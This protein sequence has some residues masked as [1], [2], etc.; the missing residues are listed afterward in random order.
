MRSA[1]TRSTLL[2]GAIASLFTASCLA[3]TG[4]LV[5][6]VL[7]K[8]SKEQ[9]AARMH[10]KDGKGKPVKPAKSVYWHDHFVFDGMISLKLRPG[11]YEYELECGPEYKLAVGNFE[12]DKTT[13][14]THQIEMERFVDMRK[15]GWWSGDLHVHRPV[16][17]IALLMKA[18]DLYVA[19]VITWWNDQNLWE[20]KKP[21]TAL[22]T[23]PLPKHWSNVMAGEDER[24]GG[25][26]LF[27]GLQ[28]PLPIK[29]LSRDYPSATAVGLL[30]RKKGNVHIDG[31]KPFWWE[32]PIWVA[33]GV[34]DSVGIANNHQQRDGM[35]DNEAWGK[36][37][38]KDI[39]PLKIDNGAWS[40]EIYFR[41]LNC[42]VRLPPS[43]GSASGV[44][45]NPVGYNRV[46]VHSDPFTEK[47]AEFSHEP[48]W[49]GLR[50]G[51][52]MVTNGPML[53]PKFNGHFA[54]RV[55]KGI[56]GEKLEIET[57]AELATRD[58][59]VY[60]EL[61]KDGKVASTVQLHK[62]VEQG[63]KLPKVEFTESGWM[64][65]RTVTDNQKTY[66]FAM[67]GPIY[68]EIEGKPRISRRDTKFFLD[69]CKEAKQRIKI[70]DEKQLSNTLAI[71]DKAISFWEEKVASANAD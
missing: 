32:F 19:P 67:S 53:R 23:E 33:H 5:I 57:T 54:G 66:R 55:F 24:E 13:N 18:E 58:K 47:P 10:L 41:L 31:E 42:G 44:L 7:D 9:V 46:Y 20:R 38:N 56:P 52:V 4:D 43:A 59:I 61:I 3:Q 71:Y 60:F 51:R 14:D 39:Y 30:A 48:W 6:E 22:T 37:R 27:F 2:W 11:K 29:G 64:T 68:V 69:W 35:M 8:K 70:S 28:E 12:V 26:L 62:W 34:I 40:M 45:P 36:P 16:D 17:D 25:A 65:V 63:G 1:K 15:E 21:P 50:E 49:K